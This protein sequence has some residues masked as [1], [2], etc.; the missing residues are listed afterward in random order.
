V[1][2]ELS[3]LVVFTLAC[4]P[5]AEPDAAVLVTVPPSPTEPGD[6][7]P[8][9]EPEPKPDRPL[10]SS[11]DEY[12]SAQVSSP[13]E[14]VC[15]DVYSCS[16]IDRDERAAATIELACL[17]ACVRA[18]AIFIAC[19]R[20]SSIENDGCG[21]Y[22]TCVRSAWPRHDRPTTVVESAL[23]G[24]DLACKAL[25]RCYNAPED[26]AAECTRQCRQSLDRDL[27][28]VA[29]ACSKLD[30]CVAIEHCIN[31]LPGAQ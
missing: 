11:F 5:A 22:M 27:Q 30:G 18:P 25:A 1:R 12:T 10:S 3:L 19:E 13:C 17:D 15:A 24:C 26:A 23:D 8:K 14:L 20:P 31:S 6:D 16:L 7:R 21:G 2:A 29:A 4:R 9:P 28:Q